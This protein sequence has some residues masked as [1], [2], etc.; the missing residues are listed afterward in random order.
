MENYVELTLTLLKAVGLALLIWVLGWVVGQIVKYAVSK[1]LSKL[2]FDEWIKKFSF[3]RVIRRTGYY[4][5]E[6][7]GMIASWFIYVLFL[8][9]GIYAAG[10]VIGNIDIMYYAYIIISVYITGFVK[11]FLIAIVSFILIDAFIS[12]IYKSTELRSEMQILYPLAEYLR[13]VLYIAVLVFAVEQSGLGIGVLPN[14]L[15]P[16]IWG[17]TAI[18][19]LFMLYLVIQNIKMPKQTV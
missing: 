8:V 3:G 2:G 9:L 19:I 5:H 1:T 10:Y 14:L 13:I 17:I 12:Y 16:I 7:L 18:I 11:L 15:T 4:S 6:F